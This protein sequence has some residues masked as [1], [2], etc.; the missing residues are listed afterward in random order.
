M[1]LPLLVVTHGFGVLGM[2][3]STARGAQFSLSVFR[4][5]VFRL[6]QALPTKMKGRSTDVRNVQG[7]SAEEETEGLNEESHS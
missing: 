5:H 2:T 6:K 3:C 4:G 1:R 7:L